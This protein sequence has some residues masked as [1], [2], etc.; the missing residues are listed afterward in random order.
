MKRASAKSVKTI[1]LNNPPGIAGSDWISQT[2]LKINTVGQIIV[3]GSFNDQR[4]HASLTP[5]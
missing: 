1:D 3:G 4:R 2:A 5:P